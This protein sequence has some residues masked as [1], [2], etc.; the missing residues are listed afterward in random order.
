MAQRRTQPAETKPSRSDLAAAEKAYRAVEPRLLALPREQLVTV[1]VDVQIAATVALGVVNGITAKEKKRFERLASIDE[2]DP[3][4][5]PD[6]PIV[7]RAAFH[8]RRM[9]LLASATSS[10]AI[11]PASVAEAATRLKTRMMRVV[12]YY[13]ADHPV[14]GPQ[15]VAIR[16]GTG[17]LDLANDLLA[18]AKL[19]KD[20]GA[21]LA[22]DR[23]DYKKSDAKLARELGDDIVE[24]LGGGVT[25]E[26]RSWQDRQTRAFKLLLDV[27]GE[28]QAAGVFL[29][30]H[31][32]GEERFPSL[33]AAARSAAASRTVKPKDAVS[34][35]DTDATRKDAV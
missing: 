28:V 27:Y 4:A 7:A 14:A 19:Y 6:L 30:R 9:F 29:F 33:I 24:R 1:N 18:L 23:K 26:A 34:S 15:I 17:Y 12:E 16:A 20:Y 35:A 31:E 21:T 8:A 2:L 25:G 13:L 10:E 3:K 32:G 11:L 5:L 22:T